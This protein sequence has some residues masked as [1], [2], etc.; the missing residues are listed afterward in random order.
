MDFTFSFRR[1]LLLRFLALTSAGV[2][3]LPP[4]VGCTGGGT[5]GEAGGSTTA[6]PVVRNTCFD[7]PTKPPAGAGGAGQG[8]AGGAAPDGGTAAC[9]SR[10]EALNLFE[11]RGCGY[12]LSAVLSDGT[13]D[14]AQCCYDVEDPQYCSASGRAFVSLGQVVTAKATAHAGA[15]W[16]QPSLRPELSGLSA[17]ERASLSAAWTRDGLF[18][19]AS[20]ASFGRFAL[21]LLASGAPAE[22]VTLAHRAA[23]DEVRHA[24]MS[25]ALASAYADRPIAPAPFPFDGRIEVDHD[26]ASLAART[27]REACVG[28]TIA[29]I[30]AAEQH[31]A[32][33]DPAAREVLAIL[34]EDEARH[35]E[36]AWRTVAWAIAAG[37]ERVREAVRAAFAEP[38]LIQVDPAET[39]AMAAHGRLG[40]AGMRAA[41]A[42]ALDEVIRPA[43]QALLA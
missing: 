5:G 14:G 29:A 3:L 7:W 31:A 33:T 43:S 28:E 41:I 36:L 17:V 19:H 42:R 40:G 15:G 38:V 35:A 1:T 11:P 2:A 20:I 8:G 24:E 4:T 6:P 18:E 13:Y 21:E 34:A 32:A 12:D 9:P 39:P 30:Q 25:F 16:G 23:I 10:K 37:G 22:L 26:L 27:V